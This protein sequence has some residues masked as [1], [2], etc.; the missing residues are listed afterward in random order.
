MGMHNETH[1]PKTNNNKLSHKLCL[2][3]WPAKKNPIRNLLT[4]EPKISYD[5]YSYFGLA[6]NLN[7][8]DY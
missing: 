7:L 8:I 4:I 6:I 2:H 1:L 3:D 5:N